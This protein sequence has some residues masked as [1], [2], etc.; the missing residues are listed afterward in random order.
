MSNLVFDDSALGALKS[1]GVVHAQTF[2]RAYT[3]PRKALNAAL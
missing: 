3:V 1:R 2:G